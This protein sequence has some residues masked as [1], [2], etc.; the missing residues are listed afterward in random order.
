MAVEKHYSRRFAWLR[1][2]LPYLLAML[3]VLLMRAL[4]HLLRQV[5]SPA[6][7]ALQFLLPVG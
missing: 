2:L 5:I 6:M 1:A 3:I 7:I 4:L